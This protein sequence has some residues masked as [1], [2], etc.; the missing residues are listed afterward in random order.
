[1]E[2]AR[3][4]E[5]ELLELEKIKEAA[6]RDIKNAPPGTLRI[7]K[8]PTFDQ[9]YWRT[10]PKDTRG[11]YIR[12]S[13]EE[14]IKGLAQKE[15]AQKMLA[16][17]KPILK[18]KRK[19]LSIPSEVEMREKMEQV[20][21]KLSP[22]RQKLITPYICAEEEYIKQWESEK[23]RMKD[24]MNAQ[25]PISE[26]FT[27]KGEQVR[28]KSEKILAD[29]LYLREIP[30]VYEAPLYLTGYGYIKPD[31]VVLNKRTRREYYW[32]H[33][34][35]MDDKDYCEKAIKKIETFERNGIFPG[36]KLILT[37]ETREHPLNMK[38]VEALIK[39]YL[40]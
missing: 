9:Y 2:G 5:Q 19:S 21:E 30:Y 10:D 15:Y 23:N 16:L 35:M 33:L 6:E 4:L 40:I 20:Y 31:F 13:E 11:K 27:E 24:Q 3:K 1:M 22:S 32:E 36:E 34:G 25:P 28:S 14:L 38:V 17:V 8:K 18:N 39:E 12:K 29:K 37:H 7:S 26:I